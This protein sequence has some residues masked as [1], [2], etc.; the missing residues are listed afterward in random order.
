MRS[1][2][3][4]DLGTSPAPQHHRLSRRSLGL[5]RD[6]GGSSRLR[7]LWAWRGDWI[8]HTTEPGAEHAVVDRA[9]ELKKQIGALRRSAVVAI[10]DRNRAGLRRDHRICCDLFIRRLTRTFVAPS[11]IDVPTRKLAR[12]R[13]A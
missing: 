13:L 2:P 8:E 6:R 3:S 1:F 12:R 10:G 7:Q 5:S 9:A 4:R 11:V